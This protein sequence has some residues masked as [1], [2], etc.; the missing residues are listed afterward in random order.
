MSDDSAANARVLCSWGQFPCGNSGPQCTHAA[1]PRGRRRALRPRQG[2]PHVFAG[3]RPTLRGLLRSCAPTMFAASAAAPRTQ[4]RSSW[5]H[6]HAAHMQRPCC[7][8][9]LVTHTG[10]TGFSTGLQCKPWLPG[11]VRR[12][13]QHEH[14]ASAALLSQHAPRLS[15]SCV[16]AASV[17]P[18]QKRRV[19][20]TLHVTDTCASAR[21]SMPA[22]MR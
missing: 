2:F 4:R 15:T 19:L 1:W 3:R 21:A 12:V 20:P 13:L 6:T 14:G 22:A 9:P 11:G 18:W 17:G 10:N 5:L 8:P 7:C 16:L